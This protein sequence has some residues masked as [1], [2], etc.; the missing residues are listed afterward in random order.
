MESWIWL[1]FVSIG[2]IM[3]LVELFLGID[4]GLDMVFIGSAFIIGGLVTWPTH[5]WIAALIVTLVICILYLALGRRFVHRW[6]ATRKERTNVDSIID[7]K[8]I[9]LV[10]ISPGAH[11]RVKV[12]NEEWRAIAEQTIEKDEVI[13]VKSVNGVT[14]SVEKYEGGK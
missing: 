10:D 13:I 5:S 6:T 14:L 8:G 9:A 7:R 1:I 11:G 2:L 4:T 12:G 3:I